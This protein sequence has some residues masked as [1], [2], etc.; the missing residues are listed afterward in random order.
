MFS[1]IILCDAC[2]FTAPILQPS[3][4]KHLWTWP[5][6]VVVRVHPREILLSR[7]GAVNDRE[8]APQR[9]TTHRKKL[10]ISSA[11]TLQCTR[12]GITPRYVQSIAVRKRGVCA[13]GAR[14]TKDRS[15]QWDFI[16]GRDRWQLSA[17]LLSWAA[18]RRPSPRINLS[19][20]A[21]AARQAS[22]TSSGSRSASS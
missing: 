20:S 18:R 13:Y 8:A 3:G 5:F 10:T 7:A 15:S 17:R 11:T 21:R 4:P 12:E 1:K 6:P 14:H 16:L 19:P 2:A 22:T 9:R